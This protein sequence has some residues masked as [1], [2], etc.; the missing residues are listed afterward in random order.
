MNTARQL[1]IFVLSL[2][3]CGTA[4]GTNYPL[5]ISATNPR[6][7]VD[8]NDVPFLMVGDSP[9][10]LFSNL[11]SA[12]AAVYLTNRAA[13]GMN[14]LWVNLLCIRPVEGRPDASLLD[15]T[16]PF[17]KT[18][19]GTHF[20]DLTAPNEAYFAHVDEVIR[21]AAT[22]GIAVMID[23]LETAGPLLPA[24]VANGSARC[25]AYGEYLGNRF[26]NF[27]NVMWLHAGDFEHWDIA[28]NDA[29]ITALALGIKDKAPDQLQTIELNYQASSSL[30]DPNW[31]PIV[32]LN[33]AY[34]YY[35]TYAEVLHAYNQSAAMPVFMGEANFEGETNGDEDGGT[36]HIL[37]MQEYW[38]MLSGADGQLYGDKYIWRFL[39]GW[40]TNLD[41]PGVIQL[42][43]LKDLFA[44]HKWYHLVP[45][46]ARAFV[47]AGYGHFVSIAAAAKPPRGRIAG[48][49]YVT[50]ALT[51][52]G[53]LGMAYL[54]Q[55]G[56]ITVDMR[57]LQKDVIARWFDPSANSFQAIAG[58][59]FANT[60]TQ[61]FTAP[62][63]NSAG[64]P[65]WVLVL[66]TAASQ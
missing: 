35:P 23:P 44:A 64:E 13:H 59:P 48:N 32:G 27:P 55:G 20:Y 57:K 36:P 29:V 26:R 15:G 42:G 8:Q 43:Y 65:D 33:L 52:D 54:P 19:P 41:T 25:R 46:Q 63:K 50:A 40:Q 2:L 51:P 17:T 22:N 60:G 28:T 31:A 18:I 14:S 7:L 1:S 9:H 61:P 4:W 12:D 11:S 24:G 56:T 10:G 6:I 38:T 3:V 39:P 53:T 37:R 30:D 21:M 5:K 58:S 16:R 45:D 49:D 66:E 47:T 34:S 62:G